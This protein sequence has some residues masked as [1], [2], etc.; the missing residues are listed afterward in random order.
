MIDSKLQFLS[1]RNWLGVVPPALAASLAAGAWT[2]RDSSA[3]GMPPATSGSSAGARTYNVRDFGA[4]GDGKAL[5]TA[6]VQAAID[7]C[8]R[9]QGG[10][11]LVPAGTFLIGTVEMR[12]NVTLRIAVQGKLL[13]SA[14]GSQYH[15]ARR[16]PLS[17]DTTLDD[18]NVG[19]IF[20][21]NAQNIAIEGPGTI[22]GQGSQF[23]S[24]RTGE[25]PPSGRAGNDRPY[26][27]LFYRCKHVR[28]RDLFLSDSAYHSV[29]IIESSFVW[30]DSIRIYNRVNF[31]NDGFH[32]ISSQYVHVSN[33]DVQSQ[34][35]ACALFGSCRNVTVTNST[36]STRWAVF[37]FGGGNPENIVISNC[38]IYETYGCPIKMQFDAR[39]QAQNILFSN[40]IMQDV[41]GPIS[42]DLDS[43]MPNDIGPAEEAPKGF[44][45]NIMFNGVR[46]RVVAEG[47]HFPDMPF[48]HHYNP[49]ETR[50]CIVL[51]CVQNSFLQDVVLN[52]V[53]VTYQG[54]GTAVEAAREVPQIAGEYFEIGTPPAY[55][56]YARRV[57]G[58]T[59]NNVRF[60]LEQPDLRPAIVLDRVSD[61]A[62]NGLTVRGSKHAASVLRFINT[63]EVLLSAARL[64]TAA[65]VFLRVEGPSSDAITVDGGALS[66]AVSLVAFEAGASPAAVSLRNGPAAKAPRDPARVERSPSR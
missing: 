41:T 21:V 39:S 1:R 64:L 43:R 26:H 42:I 65:A 51:N 14:D 5:D 17:G 25:L 47:G 40:L 50:Q 6:A 23:R 45:R 4:K 60:Q 3:P 29:R 18:G 52:D 7:A 46:A 35:D 32:F 48:E 11:V 19:L 53:C 16:I 12:S 38:I 9:D 33:C 36:F 2:G 37:R 66:R 8:S 59:L 30:A 20:A 34:D 31:N 55:G 63:Q 56:L 22:D 62:M 61:A 15:P 44:V 24:L 13:G 28:L 49:G 10:T 57:R 27:L 54:G 58:L